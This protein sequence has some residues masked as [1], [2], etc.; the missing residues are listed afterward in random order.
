MN[1]L[2]AAY[3]RGKDAKELMIILGE[4][5]LTDIDKLYAKFADEFEEKYVNQGY[6]SDRSIEETLDIGWDLLRI[7]P[8]SELKRIK[9]EFLDQYYSKS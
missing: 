3:A 5:A 7:L 6:N 1:Q 9:D 8:R 4:A 2:F